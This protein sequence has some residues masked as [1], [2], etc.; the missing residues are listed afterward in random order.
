MSVPAEGAIIGGSLRIE[1]EIGRGA[2]GVVLEATDTALRRRVA[3]KVLHAEAAADPQ[4]RARFSRE[5][6]ALAQLANDHV[7]RV[8][9]VGE[10]TDGMPYVVMERL[11]G[12]SLESRLEKGRLSVKEGLTYAKQALEALAAAHAAGIIHRDI[13]PANLF[14]AD[15]RNR[16]AIIKVLDFGIAKDLSRGDKL[17]QT[18]EALGSPAYMSPEQIAGN[19]D[20]D[21][22]SDVWSFGVT[23][24]ELLTGEL[25]FRGATVAALLSKI[26]N[27]APTSMRLKRP[28]LPPRL[29]AVVMRCLAKDPAERFG[30]AGEVLSE[31]LALRVAERGPAR[32]L[33][34]GVSLAA[35]IVAAVAAAVAY[36][37]LSR[38]KVP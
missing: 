15:Q 7:V 12:E 8:F 36:L 13:K 3:V 32:S 31:V 19:R 5:A 26:L 10:L 20:L 16:P 33:V 17:T 11:T 37:F 23:F 30:S 24:Y 35:V 1:R 4:I 29:D 22:R 2:M 6:R 21:A 25:P 28:D 9:A 14:L 34:F 18:G 38:H 27:Q